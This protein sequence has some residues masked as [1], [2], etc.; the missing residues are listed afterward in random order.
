MAMNESLMASQRTK[1]LY[2]D[3]CCTEVEWLMMQYCAESYANGTGF[4]TMKTQIHINGESYP[5]VAFQKS[6]GIYPTWLITQSDNPDLEGMVIKTPQKYPADNLLR[7][8]HANVVFGQ[9]IN[10]LREVMSQCGLELPSVAGDFATS[11]IYLLELLGQP[12]GNN[13]L[14]NTQEFSHWT[15]RYYPEITSRPWPTSIAYSL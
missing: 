2:R 3:P 4:H 10:Q 13:F 8:L 15:E 11:L 1:G 5:I 7:Y 9:S 12:I 14:P 6:T